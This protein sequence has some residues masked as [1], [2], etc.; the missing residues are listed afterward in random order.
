MGAVVVGMGMQ[1]VS[2]WRV[3]DYARVLGRREGEME[4]QEVEEVAECI[5]TGRLIDV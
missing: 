2:A 5:P 3:R 4:M 1:F